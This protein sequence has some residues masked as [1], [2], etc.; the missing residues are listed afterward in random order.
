VPV[1]SNTSD[2]TAIDITALP[3]TNAQQVDDSG[4]TYAV[5]YKR[6]I[7]AG[8]AAMGFSFTGALTYSPVVSIYTGTAG[9][10]TPLLYFS[11]VTGPVQLPVTPGETVFF[12]VA[13]DAGNPTPANLTVGAY[14]APQQAL[15][16]GDFLINDDSEGYPGVVLDGTT[17]EAKN[18]IRGL[19]AGEA[20]DALATGE[21]CLNDFPSSSLLFYSSDLDLVATVAIGN[22][23]PVIRTSVGLQRFYAGWI[24]GG[25]GIVRSYSGAGVQQST[26]TLAGVTSFLGFAPN[27]DGTVLYYSLSSNNSPLKRWDL[28]GNAALADLAAATLGYY[29]PDILVLANGTIVSSYVQPFLDLQYVRIHNAAGTLL[30]TVDIGSN[31]YPGGT[32][33]RLALD[34]DS[35]TSVWA[36]T[37]PTTG[38]S[39]LQRIDTTTGTVVETITGAVEFEQ[40]I[41]QPETSGLADF[42]V[43]FSCPIVVLRAAVANPHTNDDDTLFVTEDSGGG[44]EEPPDDDDDCPP[45][46]TPVGCWTPGTTPLG[47]GSRT[48]GATGCWSGFSQDDLA[49]GRSSS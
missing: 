25:N 15:A 30:F 26:L 32:N 37:H 33:P 24:T 31:T 44:G 11:S 13:A 23:A 40:G 47:C 4:T 46:I 35:A 3:Y 14:A 5:W 17:G 16:A 1:P 9:S 21:V 36:W 12:R 22:S 6:T 43:S 42:G 49:I 34:S 38:L 45:L 29:I 8:E 20:G 10:L 2:A 41:Y 39:T 48:A 18:F 7:P 28:S 27:N 19:A